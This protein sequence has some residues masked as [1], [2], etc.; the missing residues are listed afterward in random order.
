MGLKSAQTFYVDKNVVKGSDNVTLDSVDLYFRSKPRATGN[1][2]GIV[3]PGAT[4]YVCETVDDDT[5]DVTRILDTSIARVEYDGIVPSSDASI[6]TKFK[7]AKPVLLRTNKSYAII[8][9]CDGSE[10]FVLWKCKE[11]ETLVGTNTT[12]SGASA[13]NVGKY[14]EYTTGSASAWKSLAD[15]DLKFSII[16][17]R[18]ANST[19]N[20]TANTISDTYLMPAEPAEYVM[21]NRYHPNSATRK[22]F[23]IGEMVFQE[24]PVIYGTVTVNASS[25]SVKVNG[26][27]INFSTMLPAPAFGSDNVLTSDPTIGEIQYIVLRNGANQS[28]NTDVVRVVSIVSN[29]ELQLERLPNFNSN[30]ATFS[31]TAAGKLNHS[32]N[33]HVYTGRWFDYTS[34]TMIRRVGFMSDLLCLTNTN[35]NSSVRFSNNRLE[36]IT[37]NSGGISYSN[38]D[39]ITVYPVTNANTANA[40]HIEYIPS[41]ANAVANVVTNGSGTITGI[42]ITNAG[43]GLMAANVALAITTSTGST[44]NLSFEIGSTVRGT[45][46]N[47]K[48]GDCVMVNIP[49]HRSWSE[50]KLLSNQHHITRI[51]Q[52]FPYYVNPTLE[53]IVLKATTALHQEITPET[54]QAAID[55]VNNDGRVYVLASHSNE[56]TLSSNATIQ[57]ANGVSFDTKVKSSSLIELPIISNNEFSVPSVVT[58]QVYN[59]SYIINNDATGERKGTGKALA[60]HVSEKV[61]FAENRNA[62]D[63]VVYCDVYRPAGTS[64][65]V[66]ARIHNRTDQEAFDDKDWTE[67]EIKSNNATLT[68][69]LTDEKD[70]IELT[71]GLPVSPSSVN[72]IAGDATL[73]LSQANV[74]GIGTTWSTDLAVNDVI[75]LYS[76]LFPEN[77]MISV[78]RSITNN[79]FIT[80][81]D[82][83]SNVNMTATNSKI[84]LIGRPVSGA[85]PEIGSPYQAF[86][87]QPNSYIVRYYNSAMGKHDTYN[88]FQIKIVLLSNNEAIVPKVWNTRAVGVSA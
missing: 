67:L 29:T 78:V 66:Y 14:Y 63:I 24:T 21:F 76:P 13:R 12:T 57:L 33:S 1:R 16:A 26:S 48:A 83:A 40:V 11:G 64:I 58:S 68:S 62:E 27:N 88:T 2:S 60:R 30:S 22:N 75:K 50:V 85:V 53:H 72:T 31:I 25:T 87:Y 9:A 69:S 54:N 59:Y 46:T 79:T 49:I 55:T 61:T 77:Y 6:K 36:S 84:D 38:S 44:A 52:H 32:R 34:N 20:T 82:T 8:V 47:A 86:L 51:I 23:Q 42:A 4:L 15:T 7:F 28:A 43:Y 73:T 35:A 39:V 56:V 10:E 37:I 80:I 3:S 45:T 18:Y 19:G 65:K 5:P 71:Y 41:Y 81:D 74:V 17:C 70:L